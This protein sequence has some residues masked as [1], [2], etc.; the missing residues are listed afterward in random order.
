M[1]PNILLIFAD[2][3]RADALG[4][5]GNP[6]IQTPNIDRLAHEGTAFSQCMITQPTCTPSRASILTGCYP[7][8]LRSRMVGCITPDDPRFMPRLLKQAG[9]RTA[10]IGKIHLVPQRSE[11]DAIQQ[12]LGSGRLRKRLT[13]FFETTIRNF[14]SGSPPRGCPTTRGLMEL[15]SAQGGGLDEKA[16]LAFADMMTRITGLVRN[17]LLE[18]AERGEFSGSPEI[19]A[20]HIVT[21]TRGLAVLERAYGDEAQLRRIATHTIDLLLAGADH[22]R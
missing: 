20:L 5:A 7:S 4:Y 12:A 17:A 9:Y 14:R 21:V 15:T 19:S 11:P 6:I 2:E 3:L 16:R 1:P 22:R 13:A 18:G 8:A 10:S